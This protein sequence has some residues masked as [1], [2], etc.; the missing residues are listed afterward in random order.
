MTGLKTRT[1][2]SVIVP[3]DLG[4]VS[5]SFLLLCLTLTTDV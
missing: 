1:A 4:I 5:L 2:A 3:E